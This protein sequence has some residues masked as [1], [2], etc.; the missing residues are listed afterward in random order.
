MSYV[1][2]KWKIIYYKSSTGDIPVYNF[3]ESLNKKAKAKVI[4]TFTLLED[5]GI[6]LGAPRAEK[7]K[8]QDLWELRILGSDNIRI[9]YISITGKTFLL[10][11]GFLKKKQKTDK[12]EIKTAQDRLLDYKSRT[13]TKS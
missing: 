6:R 4:N 1:I 13:K 9:F 10:L 3:I 7:L 5:F 12:K 11:H 2:E 8:G